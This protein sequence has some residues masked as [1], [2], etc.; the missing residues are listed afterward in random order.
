[1][2]MHGG[3]AA[4]L[5]NVYHGTFEELKAKLGA[6]NNFGAG[7]FLMVNEGDGL[8]HNG[9]K[10]CRTA[11]SVKKVRALFVDLDGAPL[12]PALN[13]KIAPSMIISTSPN[14]Y[15]AY[16][17]V[18]NCPLQE[19]KQHQQALAKQLNGD[20]SV[21]DLPRVM[22]VPG[23]YHMKRE[24]ILVKIISLNLSEIA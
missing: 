10:T 15:H 9:A 22:R 1:M 2:T 6:A 13:Y 12:E 4:I 21:C 3:N 23:F 16:W 14:R 17:L 11:A 20:P 18:D 7:I 5:N 24:P 8:R 19:F